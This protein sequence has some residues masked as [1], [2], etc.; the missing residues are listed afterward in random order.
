MYRTLIFLLAIIL[1]FKINVFAQ[2]EQFQGMTQEQIKAKAKTMGY[3]E[4]DLLKLQQSQQ[5]STQ[6]KQGEQNGEMQKPVV[7]TPPATPPPPADYKVS[8]FSDRGDAASLQAFGYSIFSFSP[9]TFAPVENAPTPTNYILGPG[10]EI[11]LT[12]WGET[13]LVHDLTVS[14]D[15]DIYIPEIGLVNVNGL[16]FNEL[17]TTLYNRLSQAYSSLGN[18]K[19]H[20]SVSTGQ[21]RS[22]QV[23]VLGEVNKPGGYT[24]PAMSTAFTALYYSGGPGINGSLR[25]VK[26]LRGGKVFS[27]ID[28]Y[29]YL[30]NG[31][32]SKDIRLQDE[33]II[34]VPPVGRRTA[35]AGSVFHPAIYELKEG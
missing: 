34:F 14:K 17:K 15:G 32:K 13:Q 2:L 21:L 16:S 7:V 4:E 6:K 29:N 11:I 5:A 30:L 24:L 8:A 12:L 18:G 10:D 28:L 26:V 9:T 31:D 23:Y 3:T 19:T 1:L 35:I 25:K 27:E 20:F 22:V 33:D